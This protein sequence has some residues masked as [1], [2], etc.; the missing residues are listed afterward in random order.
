MDD[1]DVSDADDPADGD[2]P[3]VGDLVGDAGDAGDAGDVGPADPDAATPEAGMAPTRRCECP[4][5]PRDLD[6][7]AR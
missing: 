6:H 7:C 1:A 3:P 5:T 4:L 2:A